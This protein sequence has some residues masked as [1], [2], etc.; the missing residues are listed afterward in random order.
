MALF[1][2]LASASVTLANTA[3]TPIPG[4]GQQWHD[5]HEA[6][7]EQLKQGEVDLL[8]IGDSIVQNWKYPED[9]RPV[10]DQFYANRHATNLGIGGDRTEHVLWRLTHG[11][12]DGISPKL[13]II[14][15][16]QNNGPH[17]TA[18][19]IAE[20]VTAIVRTVRERLPDSKIL[21]LAIFYRGEQPNEEREKLAKTNTIIADLADNETIFF[22]NV[23][24]IF[25]RPDGTISA[26]L[27][28]DFEHPSPKG[29][30]VWAEAIEPKVVEL[31]GETG[32]TKS[33]MCSQP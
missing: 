8:F 26:E 1:F 17:N 33:P 10:W 13:A 20:G 21:L 18:E 23:N 2:I 12:L 5:R 22:M 32:A 25:L 24:E 30:C 11:N 7:N 31:M 15:I 6:I 3:V 16:G 27:M 28:P 9:G 29:F 4:N 19:E 14:M